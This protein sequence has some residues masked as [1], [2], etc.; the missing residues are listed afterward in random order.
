MGF[1]GWVGCVE[2]RRVWGVEMW[3]CGLRCCGSD[4]GK[5]EVVSLWRLLVGVKMFGQLEG[6]KY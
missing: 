2:G 3:C 4:G 6:M 1:L 5:R